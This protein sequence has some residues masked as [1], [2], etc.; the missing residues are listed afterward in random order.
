ME[1]NSES[2]LFDLQVDHR[3]STYLGETARWA[4]FLAIIGFI[5]CSLILMA[6]LFAGT[7]MTGAFGRLGG[8]GMGPVGGGLFSVIYIL[9]GLVNFFPCLYLYN[10]A[11]KMQAALR[12][13]DQQQLNQSFFQLKSCFRFLGIL[14]I[15]L[16]GLYALAIVGVIVAAAVFR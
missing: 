3:S 7:I 15:V 16:L 13:N 8:G 1:Q 14:M 6:A 10:F 4:K 12:H 9:I 5:F 2:T 11:S